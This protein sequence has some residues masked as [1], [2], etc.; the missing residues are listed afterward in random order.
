MTQFSDSSLSKTFFPKKLTIALIIKNFVATGGAERYAVEVA[1]RT[2]DKGHKI[3]LYAKNIDKSLTKGMT[4]FMIPEK[5]NF[6][7]ALSLYSFAEQTSKLIAGKQYDVIHSHD[8]GCTGHVSTLHTFSYKKGIENI[9]LL[10]KINDFWLSPRA[11][12]YLYMEKKQA[13]SY[14]LAAVSEIIRDDIKTYHKREDNVIII[15]PGV[16]IDRFNPEFIAQ[17]RS[18]ARERENLKPGEIVVLFVGSEFKRKGLDHLIPS[19]GENMKLFVVG[20]KEHMGHYR[21]LAK[22]YHLSD[23]ICFTGLTDNILKYYALSDI[24]VLPSISEAFGMTLLEGMAC[25]LPVVS[26]NATGCSSLIKNN[27]NGFVF[28]NNK[29]LSGILNTLKDKDIRK[30]IGNQARKTAAN[31]TWDKTAQRYEA[32]YYDIAKAN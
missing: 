30:Q 1:Q 25:G 31:H 7:S 6:S 29:E 8:K 4:V 2:L 24:V 28:Q 12:L 3:H 23:R 27:E 19:M 14:M 26:S 5:L 13:K 9:S 21:R 18:R 16:D 20:R 22:L 11:W 10:K 15:T 32:L 17:E